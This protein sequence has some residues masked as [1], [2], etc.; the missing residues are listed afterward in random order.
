VLLGILGIDQHE[1]G[2][3]AVAR[4]LRDAGMEVVYAGKFQTPESLGRSALDED[5]DVVG[6][7]VHSWEFL[8][9][10]PELVARLRAGG[11]RARIVVGGSILTAGDVAALRALGVAATFDTTATEAEIVGGIRDLL[12]ASVDRERKETR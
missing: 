12:T 5:A 10:M 8:D 4:I 6:I 11:A 7:S 3:L 9:F 2:A 1:V